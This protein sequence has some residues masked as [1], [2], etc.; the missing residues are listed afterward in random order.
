[1]K[2]QK[3]YVLAAALLIVVL[4]L[5]AFVTYNAVVVGQPGPQIELRPDPDLPEP[6]VRVNGTPVPG[7]LINLLQ[8]NGMSRSDAIDA[9]INN[10]VLAAS[11]QRLG[12]VPTDEEVRAY[13]E[14]YEQRLADLP[15]EQR[16]EVD[17]I[18]IAQG[19]PL[20]GFADDPQVFE[21]FRG[22]LIQATVRNFVLERLVVSELT[23]TPVAQI[24]DQ[25][26]LEALKA[27]LDQAVF[28]Q[29]KTQGLARLDPEV[30]RFIAEERSNADITVHDPTPQP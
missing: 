21:L 2:L 29:A 14:D 26:A 19:L 28:D 22:S 24:P 1:M 17:A 5:A 10:L 27:S 23:G 6:D 20:S 18:L 3:T 7:G 15:P 13:I 4:G 8:T 16:V 25:P 30:Q 11:A 9:A 12:V